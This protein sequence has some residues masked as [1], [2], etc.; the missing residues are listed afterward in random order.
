M[1]ER[2]AIIATTGVDAHRVLITKEAL[3]SMAEGMNGDRAVRMGAN[4]DPF[5]MP[6]GKIVK[7][8]VEPREDRH[9]LVART[10]IEDNASYLV[11]SEF[12]EQLT[13]LAFADFPKPFNRSFESV[14][15]DK[16]EV[17]VDFVNFD[18]KQNYG[19]FLIEA[20][21][22]DDGLSCGRGLGRK[23]LIPEPFIHIV[24]S[25][26]DADTI[27][28]VVGLW[29][30]IRVKKFIDHTVDE[31][32]RKVGDEISEKLSAKIISVFEAYKR[33]KSRDERSIVTQIDIPGDV[34]VILLT[35]TAHSSEFQGID[36]T[37]LRE[38]LEKYKDVLHGADSITFGREGN[39]RWKFL[40]M[41]TKAG[42]VIGTRECFERTLKTLDE[43]WPRQ[44]S[45]EN[46]EIEE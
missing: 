1:T 11:H 34:E 8:W 40:Y 36:L 43:V 10:Y 14:S 22:I 29:A 26:I 35:R 38:E 4:H 30:I 5:C 21:Q 7:A 13:L 39:D 3:E 45:N 6:C 9:V 15:S 31:T 19:R 25:H 44:D 32:F 17:L 12:R 33:H 42:Q 18:S 16:T 41:T 20:N 24:L 37:S 2:A 28:S 23:S 27:A 46:N